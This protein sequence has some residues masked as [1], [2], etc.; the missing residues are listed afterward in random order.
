MLWTAIAAIEVVSRPVPGR[1]ARRNRARP[2]DSAVGQERRAD[3]SSALRARSQGAAHPVQATA[4]RIG[5]RY[6]ECHGGDCCRCPHRSA[7]NAAV[8]VMIKT[9]MSALT[10]GENVEINSFG[11]F[12]HVNGR[13]HGKFVHVNGRRY[14]GRNFKTGETILKTGETILKTG[15]TILKTG[16][17]IEISARRSVIFRPAKELRQVRS[18]SK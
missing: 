10:S 9:I 16:E 6:A 2:Q 15:E 7:A 3:E 5:R 8:D 4:A 17:T 11:E 12:V 13:R 14:V 1:S 18:F